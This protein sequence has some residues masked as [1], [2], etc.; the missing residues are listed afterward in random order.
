MAIR[1]EQSIIE[2]LNLSGIIVKQI[3]RPLEVSYYTVDEIRVDEQS[4]YY[5]LGSE[6]WKLPFTDLGQFLRPVPLDDHGAAL[7][8][9]LVGFY[10]GQFLV[11]AQN[12]P[13]TR[14][15]WELLSEFPLVQRV[16]G[17]LINHRHIDE[18]CQIIQGL[19][20]LDQQKEIE[21]TVQRCPT[22]TIPE[23]PNLSLPPLTNAR[24]FLGTSADEFTVLQTARFGTLVH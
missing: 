5:R 20:I 13:T 14:N 23:P 4:F 9:A 22:T 18:I 11:G 21:Y 7:Q 19:M 3:N 8:I 2:L 15:V 16:A 24:A 6:W 12:S 1:Q 17:V 10:F